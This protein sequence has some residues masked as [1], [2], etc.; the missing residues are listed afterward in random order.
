[1]MP[2]IL[3]AVMLTTAPADSVHYY[4]SH[5]DVGSL[6]SLCDR[7]QSR[8]SDLLCRYRLFPLTSDE[9]LLESIPETMSH[10]SATELALLSGLW[11][12]RAGH[13]SLIDMV[14][15]GRRSH[16]LLTEAKRLDPDN[17]FVLLIE[18][19][20][21]L[22][23]PG[24][25]GGD[26]GQA[27]LA[28]RRLQRALSEMPDSRITEMEAD[29]WTWLALRKMGDASAERLRQ[30]IADQSP[31]PLYAEFLRNPPGS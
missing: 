7:S 12:Y 1:M 28:F 11:G 18:G 5:R 25:F 6:T 13:G 22:F 8:E 19:Q 14:R 15:Y 20:S 16:Q 2:A 27:L 24:M 26:A 23:R 29:L 9:A 4:Y 30:H 31:P 17:P 3:S 21:L 10:A